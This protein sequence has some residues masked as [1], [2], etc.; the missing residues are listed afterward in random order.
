MELCWWVGICMAAGTKSEMHQSVFRD[1]VLTGPHAG[2][3]DEVYK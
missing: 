3:R 2:L 1:E